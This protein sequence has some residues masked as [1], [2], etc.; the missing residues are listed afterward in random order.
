MEIISHRG[1]WLEKNEKNSLIAFKNSLK[2]GI[3]T[4]NDFRDYNG[5]IVISHDIPKSDCILAEDFF[6]LYNQHSCTGSI[7]I[8]IKSDGLQ[9]PINNL[10]LKYNI[11]NYFTFDMSIPDTISF[12]DYGMNFFSRQSEFEKEPV[13]YDEC[14]GIWLDSFKS[15]WFDFT[16]IDKHLKNNKIVSF[17]SPELHNR[18]YIQFWAFMK[19]SE[20]HKLDNC[21]LC[22]DVPEKAKDFFQL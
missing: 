21:I 8:N 6:D 2:F 20:I 11:K 16:L 9:E 12:K 13:F 14:N 22:T 1:Y 4:E 19:N 18:D 17:V 15:Q 10:L 7:A 5:Q 3:V